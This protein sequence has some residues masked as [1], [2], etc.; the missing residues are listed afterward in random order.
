M[1]WRRMLFDKY[2]DCCLVI[3]HPDILFILSLHVAW[4]LLK[5]TYGFEEEMA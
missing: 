2:R 3:G 5:R 1:V 4:F